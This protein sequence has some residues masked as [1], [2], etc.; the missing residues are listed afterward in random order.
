MAFAPSGSR[1]PIWA[2]TPD[3][4][5]VDH[6]WQSN[7]MYRIMTQMP[8]ICAGRG[9]GATTTLRLPSPMPAPRCWRSLAGLALGSRLP[10]EQM[11]S[12][13]GLLHGVMVLETRAARRRW[14][15][16]RNR[17]MGQGRRAPGAPTERDIPGSEGEVGLGAETA[18]HIIAV[19]GALQCGTGLSRSTW[20]GRRRRQSRFGSPS[21]GETTG[22]RLR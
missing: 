1:P 7:H 22:R 9:G 5:A 21:A 17:R 8:K 12:R 6:T 11:D 15:G 20:D 10:G 13:Q 16:N 18:R 14:L 4:R 19:G 2:V 3:S